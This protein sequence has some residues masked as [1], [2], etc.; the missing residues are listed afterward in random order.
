MVEI[1]LDLSGRRDPDLIR[2]KYVIESLS[3]YTVNGA[4]MEVKEIVKD[5]TKLR[6]DFEVVEDHPKE[7]WSIVR[8]TRLRVPWFKLTNSK[9][10]AVFQPCLIRDQSNMTRAGIWDKDHIVKKEVHKERKKNKG[11]E[12]IY[13]PKDIL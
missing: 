10:M 11:E 13:E 6:P 4:A 9:S 12:S 7:G 5:F 3:F 8:A 2:L 1:S